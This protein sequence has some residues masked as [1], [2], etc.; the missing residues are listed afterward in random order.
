VLLVDL[1][2]QANAS[3]AYGIASP[4][5]QLYDVLSG[6]S[7]LPEVAVPTDLGHL[8]VIPAGPDLAGAEI[9]LVSAEAR[10]ARLRAALAEVLPH[11]DFVIIDCPPS[12][13]LLTL[14]A[15]CAADSV[16]IPLQGEYYALEGLARLRDTVDR[17][18][19]SLHPDLQ[20]EG[21]VLTMMDRR[22][23][24][25]RQVEDEV[26]SHFGA[27][28]FTTVIPRNVR[29]SEA[30]SHGKPILLYD[31]ASKGARAYL[32][33]ARELMDKHPGAPRKPPALPPGPSP[34]P[35]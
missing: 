3:S 17:V 22:A 27:Q 4:E 15:L 14:N 6:E 32:D 19:E 11:Y 24:L 12:L 8:H 7:T 13:S 5:H 2:P 31:I 25:S 21:I 9:E 34:R 1:D 29:L 20:M 28:V 16:L 26:R 30:P 35:D 10:E 33:L 23:N 18:R